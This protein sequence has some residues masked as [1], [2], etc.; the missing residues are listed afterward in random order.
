MK[1]CVFCNPD[2][3][4]NQKVVLSNEYCV[5]LQLEQVQLKG[6]LLEGAGIIIP[7]EHRETAFDLTPNEWEATY[8][9]LQEVKKYIDKK[10]H[11]EGYNLGWNCGEVG[12]QH[13][14][15]SHFH[16]LPRYK[17]EPLA[18]KGIR[19]ALKSEKNSRK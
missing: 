5:F 13:I 1:N 7:K 15:H 17:D 4:S 11:P 2:L 10:H 19:Y 9:L 8:N 3:D 16:V 18:G 14:F 6:S 12:G